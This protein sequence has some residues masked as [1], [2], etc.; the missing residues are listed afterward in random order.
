MYDL[1][2]RAML[3][4]LRALSPPLG[5]TEIAQ[6]QFALEVA[7]GQVEAECEG[8]VRDGDRYEVGSISGAVRWRWPLVALAGAIPLGI[9]AIA[10]GGEVPSSLGAGLERLADSGLRAKSYLYSFINKRAADLP[11]SPHVGTSAVARV[12]LYEEGVASTGEGVVGT[13]VWRTEN[14]SSGTSGEQEHVVRADIE[15][16]KQ[17]LGVR[18]SLRVNSN[19]ATASH[20]LEIA[21]AFPPDFIHGGIS[22]IAGVLMKQDESSAGTPLTGVGVKVG[23]NGFLLNLSPDPDVMQRNIELLK[24]QPW[25]DIPI[26]Y[27]D[28]QRA[29]L[30]I[31]K[32]SAGERVFSDAFVAW[33]Q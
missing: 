20:I 31:E 10:L 28:G 32:G 15:I 7:I 21:F 5:E 6:E 24:E 2:R 1:A 18:W 16:P 23:S 30:A 13:V 9:A 12:M 14:V 17:N 25:F 8:N 33:N 19:E 4:K 29:I 26:V 22:R 3:T 11:D 27:A